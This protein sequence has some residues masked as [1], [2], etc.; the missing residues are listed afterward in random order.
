VSTER[1]T[2]AGAVSLAIFLFRFFFF[3][4][5]F[6]FFLFGSWCG[7]AAAVVMRCD[8]NQGDGRWREWRRLGRVMP[9]VLFCLFFFLFFFFDIPFSL[10][11]EDDEDLLGD[12]GLILGVG[13]ELP[14]PVRR[15]VQ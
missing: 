4:F 9:S 1:T 3:S 14:E 8:P 11:V 12:D 2:G 15:R 10:C 7:S 13:S 6:F 5:L